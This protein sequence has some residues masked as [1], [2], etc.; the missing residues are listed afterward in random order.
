[1]IFVALL[2]TFSNFSI[3]CFRYGL[4]TWMQYSNCG[5]TSDLYNLSIVSL[6][7]VTIVLLIMPKVVLAFFDASAH[8]LDGFALLC[9][10]TPKSLSSSLTFNTFPPISYDNS[11]FLF[12]MC[13]TCITE[14]FSKLNSICQSCD[15]LNILLRAS[16]SR[17]IS[18]S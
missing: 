16:R 2:C 17:P 15:H 7:L 4:H 8:C 3:S 5:L 13:I 9:I 18:A 14:H 10:Y 11:W 1:I 6:S 12:P